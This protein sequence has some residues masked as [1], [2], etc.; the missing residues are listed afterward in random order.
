MTRDECREGLGKLAQAWTTNIPTITVDSIFKRVSWVPSADWQHAIDQIIVEHLRAPK[1]LLDVVLTACDQVA[2][3]RRKREAAQR[4]AEA[5]RFWSGQSLKRMDPHEHAYGL[6][7]LGLLRVALR[8]DWSDPQEWDRWVA[9]HQEAPWMLAIGE[10]KRVQGGGLRAV[11]AV[12]LT[13]WLDVLAHEQWAS[14][15][16]M[17]TCGH[18]PDPH[19]LLVC[20]MDEIAQCQ[21]GTYGHARQAEVPA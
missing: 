1:G 12:G 6:F 17:R 15:Q 10:A 19:S 18:R 20:L 21:A 13:A 3:A 4:E 11:V 7:R 5:R 14:R 2:T 16:T 8:G 9:Q